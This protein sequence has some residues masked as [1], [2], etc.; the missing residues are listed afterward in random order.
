MKIAFDHQT[1]TH[2][3]YGGIS[4]YYSILANELFSSENDVKIFA[5]IHRN[6]YL[7]FLPDGVVSGVGLKKYP[8][9]T[10]PFFHVVNHI[11]SQYQISKWKPELVHET[12]FSS[13][14]TLFSSDAARVTTVYDM[15]HEIFPSQFSFR[16]STS[17]SKRKTLNRV[18]H[19]ISISESTKRDLINLF[20]I[21][22]AKISVVHLG[23][24]LDSFKAVINDA[25]SITS[26]PFLLYVGSRFDYKNFD[27]LLKAVASSARLK[28]SFDIV[29][30]G[31]GA[32]NSEELALIRSLGFSGSQVRQCS[33][34][35]QEL[36]G[37]YGRAAAFVYPSLYEGFGLPPLEAM[38]S[39]CPVVTSNTS[40]MPEV[41]RDAGVYFNPNE[42]EDMKFAIERVVFSPSVRSDLVLAGF[43]NIKS[44]SW[45]KCAAETLTVYKKVLGNS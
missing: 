35:D 19:I 38:A 17:K 33:G 31:G 3:S 22:E 15:I 36:A 45:N 13:P 23:V 14:R 24:S 9:K 7:K 25:L 18:D 41:V 10:G 29:A 8:S 44:F 27:G 5:G 4:R 43:E 26:K 40:S 37:L 11:A 39:G 21:D 16:D 1:F 30:F 34:S 28:S 20:D 2:Q 12:Y 6:N 42:I 32:F